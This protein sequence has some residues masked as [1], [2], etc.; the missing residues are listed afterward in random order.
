MD[1]IGNYLAALLN[2]CAA[3]CDHCAA[4]CL[5]E[6][7]VAHMAACIQAD[8]ACASVCRT[9]GLLLE[10][11]IGEQNALLLCAEVCKICADEC[12]RHDNDHC[13]AC[14]EICNE[15]AVECGQSA[16]A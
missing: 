7:D 2:R 8:I 13:R 9:T 5:K 10:Q 1:T 14:A 11:G 16:V 4:A 3:V 12:S 6:A 15:C